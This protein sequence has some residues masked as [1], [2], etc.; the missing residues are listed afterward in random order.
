MQRLR[1]EDMIMTTF[2]YIQQHPQHRPHL[3]LYL[4]LIRDLASHRAQWAKYDEQFRHHRE[5]SPDTP[6]NT[7][8]LQLYVDA[9]Q[10]R[11]RP[12]IPA[13][14]PAG[15]A[16]LGYGILTWLFSRRSG[17][18]SHPRIQA[19]PFFFISPLLDSHDFDLGRGH[20][21]VTTGPAPLNHLAT[22]MVPAIIRRYFPN[23]RRAI[24]TMVDI[25]SCPPSPCHR[26]A[27]AMREVLPSPGDVSPPPLPDDD[28]PQSSLFFYDDI[29]I[30]YI[31]FHEIPFD[32]DPADNNVVYLPAEYDHERDHPLLFPDDNRY[33]DDSD[34]NR[35]HYDFVDNRCSPEPD[36]DRY[37]LDPTDNRYHDDSDDNRY[38]DDSD[39]NRHHYDFVDNRCSSEPDNDRYRLD[40]TDNRYHDDSDDN[41]YHDDSDDNRH[42]YDFVDNRCSP[43]PDNDRYRLDPT[44]NRYH[45]DS[46]DNR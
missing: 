32:I 24:L 6:W 1:I 34:D 38:H 41:R 31:P 29:F 33:H 23:L 9:L 44:D 28:Q 3:V 35:Y 7:S 10:I 15:A 20:S 19:P 46:H 25:P 18:A 40:P 42:H 11:P 4:H 14:R 26:V 21:T 13:S 16:H 22:S 2:I 37:R 30:P 45:D 12:P 36:N 43:E 8:H 5:T 17:W 39:D 27:A